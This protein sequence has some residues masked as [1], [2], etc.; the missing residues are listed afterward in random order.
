MSAFGGKADVRPYGARAACESYKTIDVRRW[1]RDGRLAAGQRFTNSWT[2]GGKPAGTIGVA[3]QADAVMLTYSTRRGDAAWKP[4]SQRVP[5][6][7]TDCHFG[8]RRPW[9]VCSGYSD[10]QYCGRRVAVLYGAG[11]FA[12]RHCHGLAY[13]TQQQSARW[14]GFTK[15]QK[16]RMR[17]DGSVNLL[18]PFPQKPP[19]MHWRTYE[20]LHRAYEIA[21]DR[22]LQGILGRRPS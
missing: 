18:E 8:G 12:C 21:K 2:F 19:R 11:I 10:G 14:R 5:I 20:Q 13:E 7:W 6:T 1:H 9:F 22:S 16:I 3:T 15:A 17:L 4:V